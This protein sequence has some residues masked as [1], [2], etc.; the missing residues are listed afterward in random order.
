MKPDNLH[1]QHH[2][3]YDTFFITHQ[4]EKV[5]GRYRNNGQAFEREWE[6]FFAL[7]SWALHNHVVPSGIRLLKKWLRLRLKVT[8]SSRTWKH[9]DGKLEITVTIR[10]NV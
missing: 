9:P 2:Q 7:R 1:I 4:P 10:E 5:A 3:E 6:F 8:K